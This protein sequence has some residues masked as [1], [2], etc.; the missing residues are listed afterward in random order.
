MPPVI[1]RSLC[2]QM[3]DRQIIAQ[4][5]PCHASDFIQAAPSQGQQFEQC[6]ER[7]ADGISRRPKLNDLSI[8]Q[9][10]VTGRSRSRPADVD[11]R[12]VID[13]AALHQPTK[14]DRKD[15][16]HSARTALSLALAAAL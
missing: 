13:P 1:L 6:A 8:S 10:P 4:L 11:A 16:V 15:G 5:I 7:L 12:I 3:K 14:K 2:R 9:H